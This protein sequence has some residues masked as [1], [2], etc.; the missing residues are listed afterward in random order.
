M[1]LTKLIKSTKK[2][3]TVLAIT[4]SGY[5]MTSSVMVS[6]ADFVETH[7]LLLFEPF[8]GFSPQLYSMTLPQLRQRVTKSYKQI[9]DSFGCDW[10]KKFCGKSSKTAFCEGAD[11]S[12]ASL[13]LT[14]SGLQHFF[15]SYKK[16]FQKLD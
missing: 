5:S 15:G 2:R 3:L 7:L 9:D 13:K 4:I 10:R 1:P 6:G 12:V 11:W 14:F 8:N 16:C